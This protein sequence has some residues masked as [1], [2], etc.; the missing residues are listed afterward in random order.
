MSALTADRRTPERSGDRRT[1]PV[2]GAT[3]IYAGSLVAVNASDLLVPMSTATGLRGIGRAEEQ[4]D[5]SAGADGDQTC[6]TGAGIYRF[7][8][9]AA[10]D[11]ITLAD[12]GKPCYGVDD[13]TVA[14]TD[15]TGTR[16]VAGTIFDVDAQGVWVDF[17]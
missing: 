4:V 5:N 13:Q 16:S 11:L 17:R 12:I 1:L 15:G 14:L 8:N 10:A 6:K 7:N 3:K 2:K 9:S